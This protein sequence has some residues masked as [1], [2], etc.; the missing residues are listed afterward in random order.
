VLAFIK[1]WL[2]TLVM[3][4]T[5]LPLIVAAGLISKT[6]SKISTMGLASY[7]DAGDIV[8]QTL[9]SIRTVGHLLILQ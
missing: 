7:R 4:S 1:G 5:I 3:L 8:E 6:L 9:G 2:L